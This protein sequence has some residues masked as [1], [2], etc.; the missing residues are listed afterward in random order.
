MVLFLYATEIVGI[1]NFEK[2]DG[3]KKQ[4]KGL[5]LDLLVAGWFSA[6]SNFCGA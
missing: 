1:L 6:F 3:F 2:M 5:R 4:K